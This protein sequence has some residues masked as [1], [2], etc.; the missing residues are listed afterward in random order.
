MQNATLLYNN[1]RIKSSF[2]KREDI[3]LVL[4]KFKM[5]KE[6]DLQMVASGIPVQK[7]LKQ[8]LFVKL[9]TVFRRQYLLD[10][11]EAIAFYNSELE[12]TLNQIQLFYDIIDYANDELGI[13]YV[14]DKLTLCAFFRVNAETWEALI[15]SEAVNYSLSM[16]FKA[17]DEYIISSATTGVETKVLS[18]AAL[19]RLEMKT[20]YG[21]HGI[22]YSSQDNGAG[23]VIDRK[24]QSIRGKL[25]I[26]GKYNFLDQPEETT[27]GQKQVEEKDNK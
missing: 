11:V 19:K 20:R 27:T 9:N 25:G 6:I 21:G 3:M 14:P 5:Q 10:E 26:G 2:C 1:E 16:N 12:F 17:L 22:E 8:S 15:T 18:Q 7:S 13:V 4:N 23:V 24:M